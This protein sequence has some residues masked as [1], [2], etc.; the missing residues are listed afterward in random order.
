M[1]YRIVLALSSLLF[2][3]SLPALADPP[4][5]FLK[6][7]RAACVGGS[8][9]IQGSFALAPGFSDVIGTIVNGFVV[10]ASTG[11]SAGTGALQ[12][13]GYIIE[14]TAIVPI[15]R[16][17]VKGGFRSLKIAFTQKDKTETL[18]GDP[19]AAGFCHL[20][21]ERLDKTKFIVPLR[22]VEMHPT[23][24]PP[25]PDTAGGTRYLT[26]NRSDLETAVPNIGRCI[27][28][29]VVC[30][31]ASVPGNSASV[32]LGDCVFTFGENKTTFISDLDLKLIGCTAFELSSPPSSPGALRGRTKQRIDEILR[33]VR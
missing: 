7:T 33:R 3:A 11:V 28:T 15:P 9:N 22:W 12:K 20:F 4:A 1:R 31:I 29:K 27:L 30:F 10:R 8:S 2:L 32:Y 23:A 19:V 21:F 26:I 5:A 24:P 17:P 6:V 13:A 14:E 16:D 18:S 25:A